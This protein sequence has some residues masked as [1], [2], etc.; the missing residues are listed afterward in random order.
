L[1]GVEATWKKGKQ[2]NNK[3][4]QTLS[5]DEYLRYLKYRRV[6]HESSKIMT[7]ELKDRM[8]FN[9]FLQKIIKLSRIVS[10]IRVVTMNTVIPE[11]IG[12]R[13]IIFVITHVGRDDMTVF[14]EVMK[15]HYTVLSGDYESLCD[16]VEGLIIRLNGVLFFDMNS[17][18][19]RKTIVPRVSDVLESGDNILCS[20]EAA[21]NLSPNKLVLELF[22]GM[23]QAA[24]NSNAVILPVGIERFS[25]TLYGINIS[26]RIFDPTEYFTNMPVTKESL[27][28]AKEEIR[29]LLASAK[30]ETYFCPEIAE[31]I[32]AKRADIGNYETY[33]ENFKRDILKGWTFTEDDIQRKAF[34]SVNSPE[35]VFKYLIHKYN[36]LPN[37]HDR[38]F[39]RDEDIKE[40]INLIRDMK[41]STYP[42]EI[43]RQLVMIY[44]KLCEEKT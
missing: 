21:W 43:H 16:N 15:R 23:I 33:Y 19:E 38:K 14:N 27:S 40:I 20:M 31:K 11:T 7:M 37:H 6:Q 24:L 42:N 2:L 41:D 4:K 22:P 12:N 26:D 5:E 8:V 39:R 13:P 30:F 28:L 44:Q 1:G 18:A 34:K 29:N 9:P 25:N 32:A 17:A 3:K 36:H 35:Y 10:K